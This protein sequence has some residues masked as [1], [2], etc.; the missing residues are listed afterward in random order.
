MPYTAEISRVNPSCILFL[1]DQSNSMA[2]EFITTE[3]KKSKAQGVADVINRSLQTLISK[4]T[5]SAGIHDYYNVGV[6]AYG[7]MG[8]NP[9]LGSGP[10][11]H[12]DIVPISLIG[13]YPTRV[14]QRIKRI[15]NRKGGFIEKKLN[16]PVWVEPK[17]GGVTPMCEAFKR[18]HGVINQ[19]ILQ[20][21]NCFPPIIINITDGEASDGNPVDYGR[22]LMELKSS[23][24]NV[25]LF[26]LHISSASN[27]SIQFPSDKN[28]LPDEYAQ[29][30]FSISSRLTPYMVKVICD[31]GGHA[32]ESS[33]GF[34]F[35]ADFNT[36]LKFIDIGTR[37][38][39]LGSGGNVE[40]GLNKLF[41]S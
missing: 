1:L 13:N 38:K 20:H 9:A 36:L 7:G 15:S 4:C 17:Y 11:A 32:D 26:N 22:R 27:K 39:N 41:P 16:S 23:D 21:P 10:L 34:A 35:N 31:E 33:R 3:G 19:W 5:K 6:I 14:E 2:E 25:L 24:G 18:A 30:L 8:V 40:E 12:K 28:K 37:P 29:E